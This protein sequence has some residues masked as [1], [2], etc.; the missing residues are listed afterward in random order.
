MIEEIK[1]LKL[2]N[3]ILNYRNKDLEDT[4]NNDITEIKETLQLLMGGVDG[5]MQAIVSKYFSH[6]IYSAKKLYFRTI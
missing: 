6:N 3:N 1:I 4:I 5:N 2:E